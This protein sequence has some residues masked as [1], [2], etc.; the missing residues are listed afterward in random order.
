MIVVHNTNRQDHQSCQENA[1]GFQWVSEEIVG[2]SEMDVLNQFREMYYNNELNTFNTLVK[3]GWACGD[4]RGQVARNWPTGVPNPD[5][6]LQR[7]NPNIKASLSTFDVDTQEYTFVNL[8]YEGPEGSGRIS[9]GNGNWPERNKQVEFC[10]MMGFTGSSSIDLGSASGGD[11]V[12]IE[13]NGAFDEAIS[14]TDYVVTGVTC[15]GE[16]SKVFYQ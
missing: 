16:I 2:S 12:Y 10:S 7:I 11:I 5:D 6:V 13:P 3:K 4:S 15:M 8:R 1:E 14:K 9:V